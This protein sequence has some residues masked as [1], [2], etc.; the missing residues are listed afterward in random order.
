MS[1]G[2]RHEVAP[3]RLLLRLY[4]AGASPNSLIAAANIK[5]VIAG[6][7]KHEAT[8]EIVDVLK[9]PERGLRESVVVTPMLVKLLPRPERRVIGNLR[10]RGALLAGLGLDE[11]SGE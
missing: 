11:A 3:G 1:R 6:L 9:D 8:L 10:D 4:I 7:S 2:A 5:A